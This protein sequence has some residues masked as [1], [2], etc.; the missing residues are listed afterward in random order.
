MSLGLT[1][2]RRRVQQLQACGVSGFL[3]PRKGYGTL[4]QVCCEHD[5]GWHAVHVGVVAFLAESRSLPCTSVGQQAPLPMSLG[6]LM[7]SSASCFALLIQVAWLS[8]R[9]TILYGVA[10]CKWDGALSLCNI[11]LY[12]QA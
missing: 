6:V 7:V 1:A 2:L 3:G 5:L 9:L 8:R 12:P 10:T 11:W 4:M